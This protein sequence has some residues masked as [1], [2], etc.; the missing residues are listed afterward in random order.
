LIRRLAI[1]GF[2]LALLAAWVWLYRPVFR[3]LGILFTRE[4][5]RTNQILLLGISGLLLVQAV[6]AHLRLRLDPA[7][8]LHLPALA[9]AL[10]GSLAFVLVEYY[11]DVNIL[12][13]ILFGLASYGL[14][15]LWLAPERWRQGFPAMLLVVG[16]LP[17]G[18]HLETFAG[19]PLRTFTAGLVRDGLGTLGFHAVG[20]DTILVF[21]S[22]VS[23]VDI[24]CSG[25]KSLW[26]GA[27]FLLAATW[28]EN[29]PL[30]LRWLLVAA[31]TG[32]LLFAANLLRV[33][34]LTLVGPALGWTGL[35]RMLHV[36]LGVLGFSG[37]CLAALFLIR[38][39]PARFR[40]R[41]AGQ[42]AMEYHAMPR[43]A[44]LA[45]LAA[46]CVLPLALFSS[47][48]PVAEAASA[49]APTWSFPAELSAQP[50]PLSAQ[51]LDWIR[52]AGAETADRYTFHWRDPAQDAASG[53]IV[54]GTVMLLTSR[55][56]RGQHQPERCFEVFGLTVRSSSTILAR[57]DFPLR[58]LA[59]SS[60]NA[61]GQVSAGYW[62]Q[63]ASQ[64]TDDFGQRIWADLGPQRQP[65]V[66]VTLLF[67]QEYDS[68]LPELIH[69]FAALHAT[70]E[71]SFLQGGVP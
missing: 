30:S 40:I 49:A 25:V 34:M 31:V 64:T 67:D 24:P 29:R 48:R 9:L 2:S 35:A 13:A 18:E 62:L 39:L 59:L 32:L 12:S 5:F 27:M 61:P 15:G 70:V 14:L 51:E 53:G 69:L 37:T 46:L 23:Q 65:W 36:P 1:H 54:T 3:Y 60:P 8:H 57:P 11:L 45:P 20:V 68:H 43:P 17:F 47:P 41:P 19:Y 44:W 16:V 63:S 52:Q 6:R 56:W 55:T 26:T 58:I 4:E 21:E 10:V 71:S 33:A 28:I 42:T 50:A 22:G 66:L 38:N 7:P